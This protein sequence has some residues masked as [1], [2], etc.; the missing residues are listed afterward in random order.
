MPVYSYTATDLTDQSLTGTLIA[1]TPALARQQL[2]LQG[3]QIESFR[4]ARLFDHQFSLRFSLRK[5]LSSSARR[6]DQVAEIARYL[7]LLLRSGVPLAQSLEVIT[8]QCKGNINLILKEIRDRVTNGAAFADALSHHSEWFDSL[9]VSAVRMGE[10]SGHLEESLAELADYLRSQQQLRNQLTNALTYPAILLFVGVCV[11]LFLMTF[12]IPEL[13]TVLTASNRPLPA[14][15][16]LLKHGSDFL[17]NHWLILTFGGCGITALIAWFYGTDNGRRRIQRMQLQIPI[18]G[19]LIQ[20]SIVAQF[21]QRMAILLRTGIPFVEAVRLVA[22]QTRNLLLADELRAMEK[23]V[24]SGSDIAPTMEHSIIFPPVVAHL[25]AV[26]QD[27][28]ELPHMLS[29]L[30]TR[31]EAEV[32]LATTRF[33]TALEPLLIIVLAAAVGFVVFACLMPMLEA[34]RGMV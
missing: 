18:F 16:M 27:S 28:G 5:G 6:R 20:K 8:R 9:F 24:A 34:T 21:A 3:F 17:L 15:T 4:A 23:S 11:V 30:K 1:E 19:A 14:S 22:D 10:L 31:F 7:S 2:R 13:L 26:G 12:V 33:T 25:V 32:Q 29:E